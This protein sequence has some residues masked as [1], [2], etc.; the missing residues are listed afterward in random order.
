[1]IFKTLNGSGFILMK[2]VLIIYS[3]WTGSTKEIADYIGKALHKNGFDVEVLSPK[4]NVEFSPYDLIVLGTSI[5]AG[6]T[7]SSF[8]KFIQKHI[9]DLSV[10]PVAY[11]VSCA[12]MMNDTEESRAETLAWLQNGIRAYDSIKPISIGLFGGAVITSGESFLGLNF[13]IRRIIKAMKKKM[14]SEYGK[15]DFRDWQKIDAWTLELANKIN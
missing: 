11:F 4:E 9:A 1:M 2:K 13:F 12:N 10:R 14:V 7:T 5:H 6:Q 3:S 15:S 8:R